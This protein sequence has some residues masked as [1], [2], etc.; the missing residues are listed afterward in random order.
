MRFAYPA[1]KRH[2]ARCLLLQE[3]HLLNKLLCQGKS[4]TKW[5]ICSVD[6]SAGNIDPANEQWL[7]ST[8]QTVSALPT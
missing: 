8:L 3:M 6:S 5:Y 4:Q 1:D 7:I 2:S